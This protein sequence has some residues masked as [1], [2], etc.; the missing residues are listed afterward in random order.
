MVPL[1]TDL[2]VVLGLLPVVGPE[3][4]MVKL[5]GGEPGGGEPEQ[6][7]EDSECKLEGGLTRWQREGGSRPTGN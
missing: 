2:A 7:E 1:E 6:S 5:I 4:D 3:V